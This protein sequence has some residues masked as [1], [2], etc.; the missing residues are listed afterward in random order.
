MRRR[1]YFTGTT[2]QLVICEQLMVERY[3]QD[4]QWGGPD[5]DDAHT[6]REW[7]GFVEEHATRARK[8]IGRRQQAIDLDE[9]R[10]R[11]VVIAA[12]AVAAI[13]SHDRDVAAERLLAEQRANG[14][15]RRKPR[16]K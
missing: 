10:R 3:A 11:L 5:H 15:R 12:L 14:E 13:E 8:A 6:R 16:G 9:Y 4:Q 7:L 2:E 1:V